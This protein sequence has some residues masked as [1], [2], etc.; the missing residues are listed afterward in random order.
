[1][2]APST[3]VKKRNCNGLHTVEPLPRLN[4][5]RA[6]AAARRT[7]HFNVNAQRDRFQSTCCMSQCGRQYVKSCFRQPAGAHA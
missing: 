7:L 4:L 2:V 3:I 5:S 6:L 1:M